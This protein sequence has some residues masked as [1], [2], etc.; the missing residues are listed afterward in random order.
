MSWTSGAGSK[1]SQA[2]ERRNPGRNR[3]RLDLGGRA[4]P[5]PLHAPSEKCSVAEAGVRA[6]TFSRLSAESSGRDD[7]CL[8]AAHVFRFSRPSI[9]S[10]G[11]ETSGRD[12]RALSVS[13]T[14][15]GRGQVRKLPGGTLPGGTRG[16]WPCCVLA[17]A[18]QSETF[19][20]GLGRAGRH[21]SF[22]TSTRRDSFG[23]DAFVAVHG[24]PGRTFS[25]GTPTL[26][27]KPFRAAG[28]VSMPG[29]SGRDVNTNPLRAAAALTPGDPQT[30]LRRVPQHKPAAR[31]RRPY[32]WKPAKRPPPSAPTQT[33]C[34][35]PPPLRLETRK[36][37]SA[38]CPNLNPL[39]SKSPRLNK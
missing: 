22:A 9:E 16:C 10:S 4:P 7:A 26:M 34:A 19:R 24:H 15:G 30:A 36:P 18:A 20:A 12:A 17:A 38:E 29:S 32:A 11:R 2:A 21:R 31:R 1:T 28:D 23:R 35:P 13:C 8:P 33:R 37:P 27:C 6:R 39:C 5:P 14:R 3:Q 25:G